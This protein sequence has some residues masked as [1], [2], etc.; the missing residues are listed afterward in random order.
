MMTTNEIDHGWWCGDS[1]AKV[2]RI[3]EWTKLFGHF[4]CA[5]QLESRY[6]LSNAEC[7]R[8]PFPKK[9][10]HVSR[11]YSYFSVGNPPVVSVDPCRTPGIGLGGWIKNWTVVRSGLVFS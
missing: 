11:T 8:C 9:L 2:I 5:G 3:N 4:F 10:V 6:P 1:D 7:L